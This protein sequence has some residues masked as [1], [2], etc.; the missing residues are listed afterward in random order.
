MPVARYF[1]Y[2][3]GVLLALLFVID[4]L[5][6]R[7]VEVAINSAPAIERPIVRIH[8][9]QKLPERVVYDTSLPTI[10]PPSANVQVAAAPAAPAIALSAQ[11]RVRDTFAQFVPEAKQQPAPDTKQVAAAEPR[12]PDPQAPKKRKIAKVHSNPP[13]GPPM[14]LAQQ[15]PMRV[16]QQQRFGFFGAPMWNSTW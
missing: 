12:K 15:Q 8:S 11:S 1:L 13:A 3:G 4:A 14:Y 9:T 2:V 6:P 7:D 10:V 16:A 5:V